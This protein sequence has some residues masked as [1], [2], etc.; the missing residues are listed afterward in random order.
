VTVVHLVVLPRIF[1]SEGQAPLPRDHMQRK[2]ADMG[3]L[4]PAE[5]IAASGFVFF[6]LGSATTSWHH[7]KPPYLAG[8]VLLAL[9]LSGAL[10]RKGFQRELDWPM[11]VFLLGIDS[12]MRIMDH[13]GL[14][15]ALARVVGQRFD[16]VDGRIGLFILI[17]LGVTLAVR[18]VLPVTAGMLTAVVI[19]LPAAAAQGIHPW[20]CVFC[21]AIFSDISFFRHQGTNGIMQIRAAGLFEETDERSFLRYNM[22][23]NAARVAVVF[24]SI[25]WWGWLGLL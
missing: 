14:A 9:L 10:L 17:T 6:L 24:A 20:I 25:P 4:K 2:L 13:L 15:Q 16:F 12:M 19:L 5:W 3:P 18:L 8:F 1:P 23:M 7:I 21:A 22:L 11:I